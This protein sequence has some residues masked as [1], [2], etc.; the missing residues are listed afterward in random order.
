MLTSS[1]PQDAGF[2][3]DPNELAAILRATGWECD[4]WEAAKQI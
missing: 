3:S 4:S 1:V 2:L